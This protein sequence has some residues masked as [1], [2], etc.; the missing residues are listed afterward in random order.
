MASNVTIGNLVALSTVSDSTVFASEDSGLT[1]KVTAAT[2][3]NYMSSATT[4]VAS[5][6]INAAGGI[7]SNTIQAATIGNT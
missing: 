1:R 6:L 2:L 4:I 5:G 7:S 3:K